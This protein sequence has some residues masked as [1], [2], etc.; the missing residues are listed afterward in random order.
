MKEPRWKLRR[1]KGLEKYILEKCQE[2]GYLFFSHK[3]GKAFCTCCG[4]EWD[5]K[6]IY[7]DYEHI[8]AMPHE[9]GVPYIS[10]PHCGQHLIRKNMRYGK[11]KL[12]QEGF[13]TWIS[14]AK[15]VTFAQKEHF[16]ITYMDGIP[17]LDINAVAQYRFS[18]GK[19][20]MY[21]CKNYY[22]SISWTWEKCSNPTY[23]RDEYHIIANY[24]IGHYI[25]K[26]SLD[27]VGS[28]LKYANL[29]QWEYIYPLISY[30]K[31][32]VKYQAIELLEK[33]GFK[34]IVEAK[35]YEKGSFCINWNGKTLSQIL[36][37]T[38]KEVKELRKMDIDLGDL[39]QYKN[40][41]K[42]Y[43][44]TTTSNFNRVY[45]TIGSCSGIDKNV[46]DVIKKYTTLDKVIKYLLE[47]NR[48]K[49]KEAETREARY[50]IST[51]LYDYRDYIEFMEKLGMK[52]D[53]K[54]LF[55]KDFWKAHDDMEELVQQIKEREDKEKF[56]E[57]Q[58][59]LTKMTEPFIYKDY[60]I[61]PAESPAELRTESRVLEHCVRTYTDKITRGKT[62]ILFIRKKDNPEEPLFTLEWDGKK[63]IQCR[64]K[65]NC[66]YP[67]DVAEF[68]KIWEIW[69]TGSK[70]ARKS[71]TEKIKKDVTSSIVQTMQ[72]NIFQNA[73]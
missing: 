41:K 55:P 37:S 57:T 72:N 59:A 8:P 19:T 16:V 64:G 2:P 70:S 61:R 38:P 25:F 44:G 31:Y 28:D 39:E 27:R 68:I 50:R 20:E 14:K 62:S 60:L 10:C 26:P 48:K 42:I 17:K 12:I 69:M 22:W 30:M 63:V 34:K 15:A 54:R 9:A 6:N 67:E 40:M 71:I 11:K 7:M 45:Q 49:D 52:I 24:K 1:P 4:K 58:L 73:I 21:R 35:C 51:R 33:G 53:K 3:T 66:S 36:K 65:F 43:F 46:K 29:K 5:M 23:K 32:F 47:V 18:K 13:I 56:K